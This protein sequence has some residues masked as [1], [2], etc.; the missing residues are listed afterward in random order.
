METQLLAWALD[1]AIELTKL[2]K[3]GK[4]TPDSV[5]AT[6]EDLCNWI[7][8]HSKKETIEDEAANG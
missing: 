3:D 1:R 4:H 8:S 2:D 6:A 5:M 7:E